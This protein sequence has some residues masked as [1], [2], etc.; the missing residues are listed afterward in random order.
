[1]GILSAR[2]VFAGLFFLIGGEL[3]SRLIADLLPANYESY[4][5]FGFLPSLIIGFTVGYPAAIVDHLIAKDRWG[6]AKG[7]GIYLGLCF[8]VA[9]TINSNLIIEEIFGSNIIISNLLGFGYDQI[10]SNYIGEAV[11][12][13]AG[14]IGVG[15]IPENKK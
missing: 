2:N 10:L 9:Q 5:W 7:R 11:L 8:V 1:M 6:T 12:F 15:L 4:F 3:S 14:F 13:L